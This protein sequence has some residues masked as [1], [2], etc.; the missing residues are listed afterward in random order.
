MFGSNKKDADKIETKKADIVVKKRK[1]IP[2]RLKIG[3]IVSCLFI[4]VLC[5][6]AIIF[7][8]FGGYIKN[9]TCDAVT[10]DSSISERLECNKEESVS[11]EGDGEYKYNVKDGEITISDQETVIVDVVENS[12]PSVVSIGLKGDQFSEDQIIGSGF[13]VTENGL[14]VTNRHVVSEGSEED[15]Y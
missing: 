1:G 10:E 14:I 12:S 7:L 8:W 3:C 9:W 2:T 13:I 11:Q 6:L 5:I 4:F 15:L